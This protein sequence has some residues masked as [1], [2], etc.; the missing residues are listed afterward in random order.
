MS[1]IQ[2]MRDRCIEKYNL[3]EDLIKKLC[4]LEDHYN[5]KELSDKIWVSRTTI[6]RIMDWELALSLATIKEYLNRLK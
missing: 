5:K 1:N 4:N 2:K 6:Y 3:Y